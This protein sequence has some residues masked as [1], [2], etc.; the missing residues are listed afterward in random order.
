MPP[1]VASN[2][3]VPKEIIEHELNGFIIDPEETDKLAE[4]ILR[5]LS[6]E[7]LRRDI[8]NNGSERV[9]KVYNLTKFGYSL[10]K[11]YLEGI[12]NVKV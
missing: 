11:I 4:T 10:D 8:G 3:D 12:S 1:V 6:D 9:K 7:A 2:R 5:L